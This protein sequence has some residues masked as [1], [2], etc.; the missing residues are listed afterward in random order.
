MEGFVQVTEQ[1]F[2]AVMQERGAKE[3]KGIEYDHLKVSGRTG[4][5]KDGKFIPDE[6]QGCVERL[7]AHHSYFIRE[8]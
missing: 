8:P 7:L 2:W 5:W 1:A 6:M 3:Q 4:F